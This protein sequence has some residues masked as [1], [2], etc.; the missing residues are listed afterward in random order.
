V[1]FSSLELD[2]NIGRLIEMSKRAINLRTCAIFLWDGIVNKFVLKA[3]DGILEG[4]EELAFSRDVWWIEQA[5]NTKRPVYISDTWQEPNFKPTWMEDT[6]RSFLCLPLEAEERTIGIMILEHNIPEAFTKDNVEFLADMLSLVSIAIE[7]SI[8][9]SKVNRRVK[10]LFALY[11][12]G[13]SF[14]STL[15][16]E[17][18]CRYLLSS[19]VKAVSAKTAAIYLIA[20]DSPDN[21]LLYM[22]IGEKQDNIS[23]DE[24]TLGEGIIGSAALEGHPS[25][26]LAE[27]ADGL[28]EETGFELKSCLVVPL[29]TE[30]AILG[31]L[32][33]VDRTDAELFDL[34]DLNLVAGLASQASLV[35]A[36][37]FRLA[38]REV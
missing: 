29:L 21:L 3:A 23:N 7:N 36:N 5:F 25:L 18:T 35:L 8:F 1:I 26:L 16:V 30:K 12:A 27:Q 13:K 20:G 15:D 32:Q 10:D 17:I 9:F 34:E 31:V 24:I 14:L 37:I 28:I 11:D 4:E 38:E 19:S 6:T 2:D 33:V 22:A